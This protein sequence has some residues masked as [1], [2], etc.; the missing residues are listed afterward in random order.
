M[1]TYSKITALTSFSDPLR[2]RGDHFIKAHMRI[3]LWNLK[4]KRWIKM[5][6]GDMTLSPPSNSP[7]LPGHW[8]SERF[9]LV[10]YKVRHGETEFALYN[11]KHKRYVRMPTRGASIDTTGIREPKLTLMPDDMGWERFKFLNQCGGRYALKCSRTAGG[12]SF[13]R[14]TSWNDVNASDGIHVDPPK[15]K[16]LIAE[17]SDEIFY[18]VQV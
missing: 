12:A 11:D 9:W 1:K 6:G 14:A 4:H 16:Q 15:N 7:I 2:I 8:D 3:G 10:P 5:W 17:V 18:V 13:M